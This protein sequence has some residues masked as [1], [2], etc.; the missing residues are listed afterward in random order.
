MIKQL[1]HPVT[2]KTVTVTWAA[3]AA[4]G[5]PSAGGEL[6]VMLTPDQLAKGASKAP[7]SVAWADLIAD[8]DAIGG[9]VPVPAPTPPPA[10]TPAPPGTPVTLAMATQWVANGINNADALET[11]AQAIAAA[12]AGLTQFWPTL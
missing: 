5:V 3:L 6:W 4:L 7:N 9:T 8:F 11:R 12:T 2:G 10:P 1:I